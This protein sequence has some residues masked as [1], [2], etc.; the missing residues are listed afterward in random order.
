MG[1]FYIDIEDVFLFS[2]KLGMISN[3]NN[4]NLKTNSIAV[5]GAYKGITRVGDILKCIHD[6]LNYR[7]EV[8]GFAMIR[9]QPYR[10]DYVDILIE[11]YLFK[12]DILEIE[13]INKLLVGKRLIKI[14]NEKSKR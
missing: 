1:T 7:Y 5:Y 2:S 13:E 3:K 8:I 6:E 4:S 9:R 14:E 12:L 11:P 10:Q